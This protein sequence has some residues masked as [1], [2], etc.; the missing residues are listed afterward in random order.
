MLVGNAG[1]NRLDGG[2]GA[3]A[4]H[5]GLGDDYYIEESSGDWV[6]EKAGEGLDTVERRYETELVLKDNVE[7]L[8]LAA[9]IKTGNGNGLANRITGNAGAN[10]LGGWDGNDTLLGLDGNDALFGGNGSDTLFG[11]ADDDY[12]DGGAGVDRLVGNAGNDTY[13]VDAGSDVVV[14][15]ANGGVDAVQASASYVLSANIEN[16]FLTGGADLDGS[17]NGLDNYIAGNGGANRIDGGAG[18]DTL[19]AGGGDDT[20]VGGSGDDK[21]VFDASSGSDVIDNV[22]GGFDGVFFNGGITRERL[23]FGRDGDD[24]LIFV[25]AAAAPAL[26]VSKHF[27]GGDAAIDYVQPDGGN[28]LTA[29]EINRIVAGNA[30]GGEYDQAVD[31]TAAGEQLAGSAGKDLVRGLGGNDTLFGMAGDDMLQGGDGDDYL[32]GG[33]GG[34]T[35]SGDDHLE[36]GT[37]NDTLAGEDGRNTLAG[38]AGDDK[39]VYGGGQDTIDNTGGGSDWLFMSGI[40]RARLGFHRDGDDLVVTVDGDVAH[41]VRVQGQFADA[42]H[43]LAY[44]QPGSGNAIATSQLADLLTPMPG[45]SAGGDAPPADGGADTPP[46]TTSDYDQVLEGTGAGEQLLG[47]DGR[48]LVHALAG[49]DSVFGFNGDDRLEGGDGN[50][51]LAGGNGSFA[52]SGNDVL[53][54][55]AGDDTLVG[56]DGSDTLMGGSGN[57][58]YLWQAGSGSDTIDNTGGGSDWLFMNGIAPARLG[59]H[60]DGDDLVVQVDGDTAQQ[61]RVKNHFLGGEAAIAYVQPG[62][63]YAIS[64]AQIATRLTPMPAALVAAGEAAMPH[65]RAGLGAGVHAPALPNASPHGALGVAVDVGSL[66]QASWQYFPDSVATAPLVVGRELQQLID[67]MA[68]FAPRGSG[69]D[70]LPPDGDALASSCWVGAPGHSRHGQ[71]ALVKAA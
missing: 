40:D 67:A 58:K 50:D 51:Y 61:V 54:G 32:A 11:G 45:A 22:D 70:L 2:R 69:G 64:A 18:N 27:L 7:N 14:E 31:G 63:G 15:L 68:G 53:V 37:G 20:L 25:D 59:F 62:S 41:A 16:L 5:G 21:Y 46:A 34:G 29:S 43:A 8:I 10:T 71:A 12:L 9:G 28:Y 4:L 35:G 13:I 3:D 65:Q 36:G 38:G 19:V 24:L 48:D 1:N 56:E 55:G 44:I 42:A 60:R 33:N 57:D 30:T 47:S 52:G 23:S 49:D 17:G 26:R 6:Y 66:G 39:Y